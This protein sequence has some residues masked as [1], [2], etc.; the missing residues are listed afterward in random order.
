[1][2][3]LPLLGACPGRRPLSVQQVRRGPHNRGDGFH[4]GALRFVGT[5][6]RSGLVGLGH[7]IGRQ[8]RWHAA[9]TTIPNLAPTIR[10]ANGLD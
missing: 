4:T 9:Q 1:M 5:E 8:S 7:I 10:V 2:P 3:E 6:S